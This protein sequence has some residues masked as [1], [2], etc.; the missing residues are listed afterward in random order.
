MSSPARSRT[1]PSAAALASIGLV[2][3]TL[4]VASAP[5]HASNDEYVFG[6]STSVTLTGKGF[7]HGRGMSQYGAEGAARAGH[8]HQEILDFYYAGTEIGR[9]GGRI[10]VLLT[11]AT[12]K[13]LVVRA[14][15]HLRVRDLAAGVHRL[16]DNGAGRWRLVP[17]ANGRTR[18]DFRRGGSWHRWKRLSGG[19]Q[20]TAGG[21]PIM[22]RTPAGMRPYRGVLRSSSGQTI[23]VLGLQAYLRGVV[24]REMPASWSQAALRAQTVA[25]RTYAANA[26]RHPRGNHDICDTTACQVY[27]G[28]SAHHPSTNAAV[29]ATKGEIRV[30]NGAPAFTQYSSSN[31]GHAAPG[32]VPYQVGKA[33]SFD[34]VAINPNHDWTV[35]IARPAVRAAWPGLGRPQRIIV[36]RRDGE[37]QWGGRV[38]E[39]RL[40]GDQGSRTVTGHD[41]RMVLGLRSTYFA[42][43]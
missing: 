8:S 34:G 11:A 15:S 37:G 6:S 17:L 24:P 42:F 38:V 35:S 7:G 39:V 18:V 9:A 31:G 33:D 26:M 4:T 16:P 29:R 20:F 2:A 32:T 19:G 21:R 5:A 40:V 1:R 30:H 12:H 41:F 43:G 13:N 3:A 10:R 22:L 28:F 14:R 36:T 27:G 23:N 25:A